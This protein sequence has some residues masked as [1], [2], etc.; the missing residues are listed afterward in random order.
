MALGAA[1]VL[2]GPGKFL[3]SNHP[4]GV[5][6]ALLDLLLLAAA[7]DRVETAWSSYGYFAAGYSG[8]PATLV[9]DEAPSLLQHALAPRGQEQR[10]MGVMH[11]SDRRAQCV[12]L[13][14]TEPCFHKYA[15]W[16]AD[17]ATC[18]RPEWYR[19]EMLGGRYC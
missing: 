17:T 12:R 2:F 16:G 7:D 5:Q 15:S 19:R 6:M 10:F 8:R 4:K 18:F 3:L 1:N 11:K 14:T 13:P 9:V